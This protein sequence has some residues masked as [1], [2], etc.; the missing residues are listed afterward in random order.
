MTRLDLSTHWFCN[1]TSYHVYAVTA[2]F[3]ANK[4]GIHIFYASP[5]SC[6]GREE[7]SGKGLLMADVVADDC[8]SWHWAS[9]ED[10]RRGH[11]RMD[12]V[13]DTGWAVR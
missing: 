3:I 4:W 8:I 2:R 5:S 9:V 11:I 6:W 13:T 1:L 10:V 12:N 7:R